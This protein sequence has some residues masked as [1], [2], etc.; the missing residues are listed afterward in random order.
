MAEGD[1]QRM[2]MRELARPV[3]AT[4]SSCIQLPPAA[5]NYE[6]KALNYNMLPS[7]LLGFFYSL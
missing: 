7:Y 3:I 1:E 6:T 5:R 2:E 4:S